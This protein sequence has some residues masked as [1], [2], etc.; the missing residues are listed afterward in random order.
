VL[1]DD[2]R[3]YYS[4]AGYV[5]AGDW[6]LEIAA[7]WLGVDRAETVGI[8]LDRIG[9]ALAHN[10]SATAGALARGNVAVLRALIDEAG[11]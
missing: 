3:E 7:I 11:A 10:W 8:S 5:Q 9:R 6:L 2:E 1:H 4:V